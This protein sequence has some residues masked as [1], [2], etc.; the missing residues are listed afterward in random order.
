M[1]MPD[2]AFQM[3]GSTRASPKSIPRNR[4]LGTIEIYA[5]TAAPASRVADRHQP[6]LHSQATLRN[7][8]QENTIP[9]QF[10]PG[11]RFLVFDFGVSRKAARTGTPARGPGPT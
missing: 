1:P 11:M 2:T 3:R 5:R 4:I 6:Q 7:Q 10:V 9:A 8:L